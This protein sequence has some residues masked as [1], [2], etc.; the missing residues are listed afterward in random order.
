MRGTEDTF[1]LYRIPE[2]QLDAKIR[3]LES[4]GWAGLHHTAGSGYG[5]GGYTASS[6]YST[7]NRAL[8]RGAGGPIGISGTGDV[9]SRNTSAL[10]SSAHQGTAAGGGYG[11]DL[12]SEYFRFVGGLV[13]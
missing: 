3:E 2:S 13:S 10:S 1:F 12:A 9:T 8:V 5:G 6:G 4:S 11:E 7:G